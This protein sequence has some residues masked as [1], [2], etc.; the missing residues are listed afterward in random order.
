VTAPSSSRTEFAEP[1]V[2]PERAQDARQVADRRGR[3]GA[4][5]AEHA[6]AA[7]QRV[8]GQ[9]PGTL[10]LADRLQRLG[11]IVGRGQGVGRG[12]GVNNCVAGTGA[13]L[14][15]RVKPTPEDRGR[16]PVR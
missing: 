4:I 13:N 5:A 1:V 8:L 15:V 11:R 3:A 9:F 14:L 10:V 16:S 6:A 7:G 2:L 12:P